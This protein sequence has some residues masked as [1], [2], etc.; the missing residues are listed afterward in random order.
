MVE[1]ARADLA[2]RGMKLEKMPPFDPAMFETQ[3]KRRVT[4][5]LITAK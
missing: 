4:L 2:S 5:G 3:A 1:S